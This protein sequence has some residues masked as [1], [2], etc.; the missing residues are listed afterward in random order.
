MPP[1]PPKKETVKSDRKRLQEERRT[2]DGAG[3]CPTG[4]EISH[5]GVLPT[6]GEAVSLDEPL[7]WR[8]LKHVV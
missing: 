8:D 3:G 5:D 1:P 7:L 4:Q 6:P 2:Q